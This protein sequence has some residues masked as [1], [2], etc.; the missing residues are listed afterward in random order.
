MNFSHPSKNYTIHTIHYFVFLFIYSLF[1]HL[2]I[3]V[4]MFHSLSLCV[5]VYLYK[6]KLFWKKIQCMFD[7]I[8]LTHLVACFWFFVLDAQSRA[9]A[10]QYIYLHGGRVYGLL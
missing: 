2:F 4:C 10:M 5:F 6:F 3:I 1:F 9:I 8:Q 7:L